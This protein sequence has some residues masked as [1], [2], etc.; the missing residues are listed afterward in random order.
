MNISGETRDGRMRFTLPV[1]WIAWA[2]LCCVA[3]TA[4]AAPVAIVVSHDARELYVA[5]DT[6]K[7]IAVVNVR[8]GIISSRIAVPDTAGGLVLSPD[9]GTLYVTNGAAEGNIVA[10]NIQSGQVVASVQVGHTPMAPVISADGTRVYVCNRFTNDISI[11]DVAARAEIARIGVL[12]EPVAAALTP[13]GRLLFVA[14]LLP[15]GPSDGD[16]I[17]AAVSVIDT[18]AATNVGLVRLPNGSSS[19]RGL[20]VSPDGAYVYATHILS[21]YQMPTTQV[22]RGWMNTNALSVISVEPR[23]L[24]NTVLLDDVTLGAA[25]PWA[26][27]CS[28]DGQ[29]LCVSH[30]G[31]HELSV[32]DRVGLHKK[33]DTLAAGTP[34]SEVSATA[35]DVPY[36]LSFLVGL[37]RRIRLGGN[38][39][40]AIALADTT[41]FVAEHF[42]E[43]L[44]IVDLA[45]ED[46][47]P[48]RAIALGTDAPMSVERKGEMLFNDATLCFQQWQSCATCHPDGR[49]DGLNWDL[50]NDGLGS[51]RNTKSMLLSH[52]TPPVMSLGIRETAE[53]AVRAGIR[54]IQFVERP[55][56]DASAIDSYLKSMKPA[57][58]PR[59]VHG[60]LSEAARKGKEIFARARCAACH[61]Q[62]LYTDLRPYDVGTT[63]DRDSGKPL[64]TPTL[65]EVWRTAPYLHDGRAATMADVLTRCNPDDRHGATTSLSP[66]EIGQLAEY[67]LSQ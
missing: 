9:G 25:N 29:Y 36:D 35:A 34:V 47:S 26:V 24:V 5:D 30:A 6:A 10:V 7:D 57:A 58:S 27:A 17:A 43:S 11:I 12:R 14:N 40:R 1:R 33:L 62:G 3:S 19:V 32:I 15:D 20:C 46:D 56:A 22:E 60:E 37:R 13:D 64:D 16:F 61:P 2:L 41:A 4:F 51:P 21:R 66:D 67:V 50:L 31:T 53:K 18:A 23:A 45:A 8:D 44:S 59:L 49:V 52:Q 28:A 65:V 55:E 63:K 39:P 42:S 38:G 54:F 48:K